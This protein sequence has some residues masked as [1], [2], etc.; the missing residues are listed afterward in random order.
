MLENAIILRLIFFG[1]VL[2]S[3]LILENIF[4]RRP[5]DQK[6]PQRWFNNI[7]LIIIGSIIVSLL[8]PFVPFAFSIYAQSKHIGL[9][10]QV[11]LPIAVSIILTIVLMDIIIYFQHVCFHEIKLLWRLHFSFNALNILN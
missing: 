11:H 2:L 10:N 4:P 3:L 9:M 6:R 1:G 5:L 8:M 7:V